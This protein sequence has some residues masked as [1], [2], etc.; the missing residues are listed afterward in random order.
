MEREG[1]GS[2]NALPAGKVECEYVVPS[3][4]ESVFE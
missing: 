4:V 1:G 2:N 3:I